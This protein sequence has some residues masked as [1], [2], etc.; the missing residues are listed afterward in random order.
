[1]FVYLHHKGMF[2]L[3][4]CLS[5]AFFCVLCCFLLLPLTCILSRF[6]FWYCLLLYF[7]PLPSLSLFSKLRDVGYFS[8]LLALLNFLVLIL[9]IGSKHFFVVK[10]PAAEATDPP[11]P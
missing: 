7:N 5:P 10:G 3:K 1:M 9:A 4:I 11:Q 8:Y 6:L 2:H